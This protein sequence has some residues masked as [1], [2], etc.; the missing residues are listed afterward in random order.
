MTKIVRIYKLQESNTVPNIYL[1][2][3]YVYEFFGWKKGDLIEVEVDTVYKKVTLRKV[4]EE[5]LKEKKGRKGRKGKK[6]RTKK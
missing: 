3:S 6:R 4:Q 5:D 2:K 1:P